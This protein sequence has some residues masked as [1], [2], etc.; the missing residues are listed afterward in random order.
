MRL[1]RHLLA[2]AAA[3][4][5]GTTAQA[6]QTA[7][8]HSAQHLE[9]CS[10]NSWGYLTFS[11]YHFGTTNMCSEPITIWFM[12]KSGR[13]VT[14]D[15]APRG[16]FDTGLAKGDFDEGVWAAAVCPQ[17]T[18]PRPTVSVANWDVILRSQ[19]ECASAP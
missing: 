12:L 17:G 6:A 3:A 8:E 18:Q 14:Q 19:Y 9:A 13:V 5:L 10:H 4:V 7:G 11:K 1:G 16:V 15:V 2:V